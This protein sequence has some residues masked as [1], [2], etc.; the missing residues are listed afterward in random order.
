MHFKDIDPQAKRDVIDRRT[1]FY[2]ACGQGI[3]CNLGD[4][5][6][7]LSAVRRVLLD[8]G[9]GGWRYDPA[10]AGAPESSSAAR[11]GCRR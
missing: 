2:E 3:S 1:G 9:F 5:E 7:D 11:P 6:V 4:G 8:A 10:Q